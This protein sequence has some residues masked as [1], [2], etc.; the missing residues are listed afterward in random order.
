MT[1]ADLAAHFFLF[2][3]NE[4]RADSLKQAGPV[5][6]RDVY[7]TVVTV[8]TV[9]LCGFKWK[10]NGFCRLKCDLACMIEFCE[11]FYGTLLLIW[12]IILICDNALPLTLYSGLQWYPEYSCA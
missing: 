7:F 5:P 4:R 1:I 6:Q 11:F 10:R 3:F 2:L 8:S 9:P 12:L